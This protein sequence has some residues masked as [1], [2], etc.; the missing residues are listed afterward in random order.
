MIKARKKKAPRSSAEFSTLDDFLKEKGKLEEFE[1]IAIK[2]VVD[3]QIAKGTAKARSPEL[4]RPLT[5]S[6]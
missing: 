2:E 5:R 4:S 3:W 6:D 1:A